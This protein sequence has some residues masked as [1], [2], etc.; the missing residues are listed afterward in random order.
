MQTSSTLKIL[1]HLTALYGDAIG[2]VTMNRLDGLMR[3]YRGRIHPRPSN[4][5]HRDAILITYPDQVREPNAPALATLA[6]FCAT[7]LAGTISGI[8]ILPFFPFTSDDG[9][10]VA[11]YRAVKPEFGAWG[12]IEQMGSHFRLMFDAVIN[13]ISASSAWF[14]GFLRDDPRYRDYFIVVPDGSDL[15]RVVRPRTSP[16]LTLFSTPSGKKN[17]WTTFGGDQIDLNYHNPGVLLD[18]IDTLLFYVGRGAEFIRLDAIAYLWKKVGTSCI[19]L[20]QTHQL[21]QLIRAVMDEIAPHVK[22]IT[23]TNVPHADNLSY[24]GDGSNEAALA[25]NFALPP[26]VLHAFQT[27][28]AS[29][30]SRWAGKLT[31]PSRRVTFFNFLASHDGIGLNPARGILSDAA[32]DALVARVQ[33]HGGLVSYKRNLDGAS[34]AYELNINYFDALSH[35]DAVESLD[36]QATRFITA[37]ALML[38]FVGLPGIYFHSLFGS[39]GWKQGVAANGQ[40]RAINREKLDRDALEK[41][42][43]DSTSRRSIVF[44]R[45]TQL[46]RARAAHPAFDPYGTMRI[47]DVNQSIFALV[48]VNAQGGAVICLHNVS[49]QPQVAAL[50]WRDALGTDSSGLIDLITGERIDPI[51][52]LQLAPYGTLWLTSAA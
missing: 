45:Y 23:E 3:K 34:S 24:F 29:V 27:A 40:N 39:R 47:L 20:P 19:N 50:R 18:M 8:H 17:L 22:L 33:G 21:I 42:L 44:S 49:N 16:L 7:H 36:T 9:F 28:D 6:D 48:R 15:S 46:L 2:R 26:L 13:H 38:S 1:E 25:Y 11:D 12:D 4:L 52:S 32:I 43:A 35:P 31:L 14:Q 37:Q 5:T 10:S 41:E 51:A 30:L